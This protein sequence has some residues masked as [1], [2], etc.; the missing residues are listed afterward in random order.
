VWRVLIAAPSLWVLLEAVRSRGELAFPWGSL[1]YTLSYHPPLIQ[2][3]SVG[4][5][6]ALSL[7]V[8]AVNVLFAAALVARGS[9]RRAALAIGAFA[10]VG[11]MWGHGQ[12][13]VRAQ[14]EPA[15]P[16]RIAVVQPNVD[17]VVK[18]LPEFKDST[19]RL[20]E[21]LANEAAA[22][23]AELIVF[24]E[25]SAPVYIEHN[26]DYKPKLQAIASATGVPI[27]IGFLDHRFDGPDREINI[28]NSSGLFLPDGRI[29]KY[30][31]NHLLPFGESLPLSSRFRWLRKINFGQSN[32][33]HGPARGPLDAGVAKLTPLIC[34]ESVFP[35]LCSRGVAGGTQLLVN[36]TNDGWFSDT[37]G[38]YQHAQMCIL[39]SVEFRRYLVRSAN[40]GVSMVVSPAGEIIDEIGLYTSGTIVASVAALG[41]KTVYARFG[42]WPV[43]IVCMLLSLAAVFIPRAAGES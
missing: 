14:P 41:G 2:W 20:I 19:L 4:G 32:F 28:Y 43:L 27:Y 13:M 18:W 17:L 11:L 8:M 42:D 1:G 23:G 39:R 37:P 34:F 15:E 10:V 7:A 25:T 12:S 3:A 21:R 30:D 9:V 31:K 36:I 24:P 6:P 33:Q 40:T 38:P 26:P 16:F 22:T 5:L 29:E 35:Y